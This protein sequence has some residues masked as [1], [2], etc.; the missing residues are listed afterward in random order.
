MQHNHPGQFKSTPGKITRC[1]SNQSCG[2]NGRAANRCTSVNGWNSIH[3]NLRSSVQSM[4]PGKFSSVQFDSGANQ[5]AQFNSI[6]RDQS[7]WCMHA[8]SISVVRPSD[9]FS[10]S[11]GAQFNHLGRFNPHRPTQFK[12]AQFN[13]P[14][15]TISIQGQIN[16]RS[17]TDHTHTSSR[18]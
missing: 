17:K 11:C 15:Q 9:P 7:A 6:T 1:K 2:I 16:R 5:S 12:L 3:P 8:G 13:H 4:H 10:G 18:G 14:W